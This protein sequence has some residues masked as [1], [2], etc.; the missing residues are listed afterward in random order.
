MARRKK[1]KT[2][3]LDNVKSLIKQGYTA[4]EVHHM[5]PGVDFVTIKRLAADHKKQ[6]REMF[7]KQRED[8]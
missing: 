8:S 2:S 7:K 3:E 5:K 1:S 4:H 6:R